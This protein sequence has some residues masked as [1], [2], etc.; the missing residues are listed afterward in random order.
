V[1]VVNKSSYM[2]APLVGVTAAPGCALPP[3]PGRWWQLEH[4]ALQFR[5]ACKGRR[6]LL[7]E[8][9]PGHQRFKRRPGGRK[10][11]ERH[12]LRWKFGLEAARQLKPG[13]GL[14]SPKWMVDGYMTYL[15]FLKV[16]ERPASPS[17][18]HRR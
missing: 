4:E 17:V 11:G 14:F 1:D 2:R 16:R 3:L 8:S 18:A 12:E 5:A 9:S 6:R 13:E 15:Q 7:E 10:P